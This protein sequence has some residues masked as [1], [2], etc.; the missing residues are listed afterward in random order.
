M[1]AVKD[2]PP[3]QNTAENL[4]SSINIAG[5]ASFKKCK[6]MGDNKAEVKSKDDLLPD[7]N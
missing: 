1:N 6:V 5:N 4:S 3:S 7:L 2:V